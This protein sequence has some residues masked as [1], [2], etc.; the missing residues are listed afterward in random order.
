MLSIGMIDAPIEPEDLLGND[1]SPTKKQRTSS[2]TALR[3]EHFTC[4]YDPAWDYEKIAEDMFNGPRYLVMLEKI[5]TNAHV[6]FQGETSYAERTFANKRQELSATHFIR[7]LKPSARPVKGVNRPVTEQGFQYICKELNQPLAVKGFTEEQLEDMWTASQEYVTDKK[8]KISEFVKELDIP[9]YMFHGDDEAQSR[10]FY[11]CL[12]NV[13][14]YL[15]E[16]DRE[17]SRYTKHDVACGLRAHH[18]CTNS[19]LLWLY[20]HNMF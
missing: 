2:P 20:Q 16:V 15:S 7:K 10:L 11:N 12:M 5:S 8:T 14:S 6:H 18:H 9:E 17:P 4:K 19:T 3:L 13:D 1:Q